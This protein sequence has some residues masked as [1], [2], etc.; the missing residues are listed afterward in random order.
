MTT[1]VGALSN[2]ESMFNCLKSA[3]SAFAA[4]DALYEALTG[5]DGTSQIVD[6][7][8]QLQQVVSQGLQELV[9]AVDDDIWQQQWQP[10]SAGIASIQTQ[11]AN[12]GTAYATL[13]K[14]QSGNYWINNGNLVPLSVWAAGGTYENLSYGSA[15]QTIYAQ[16]EALYDLFQQGAPDQTLLGV[17]G[18]LFGLGSGNVVQNF[19]GQTQLTAY[20]YLMQQIYGM[21]STIY[22]YHETLLAMYCGIN[23]NQGSF[24]S[25][26]S[27]VQSNFASCD[28]QNAQSVWA[29]FNSAMTPVPP[30][31]ADYSVIATSG[32]SWPGGD[33]YNVINRGGGA[34]GGAQFWNQWTRTSQY[35]QYANAVITNLQ[36]CIDS[37]NSSD[38]PNY[39]L[40]GT[41]SEVL[42]GANFVQ[43]PNPITSYNAAQMNG[44]N[45]NQY[46]I[47]VNA[48]SNGYVNV[49]YAI[50]PQTPASENIFTVMTGFSFAVVYGNRLGIQVEFSLLDLTNPAAPLVSF[51][52]EGIVPTNQYFGIG[53]N[54][55]NPQDVNYVDLRPSG[56]TVGFPIDNVSL[57]ETCATN[58]GNRIGLL[59][60]SAWGGFRASFMQPTVTLVPNGFVPAGSSLK[61]P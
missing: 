10:F 57:I 48:E 3:C 20:F 56:T 31:P 38:F 50:P 52:G 53:G 5:T 6:A 41:V 24:T 61:R 42:P 37:A 46:M 2:L 16:A 58:N 43:Q 1:A 51:L 32:D 25:L 26:S 14:D 23:E 36:I 12:F 9:Q 45:A 54:S 47:Y 8:T 27:Y 15:L 4:A 7:I 18:Q 60:R 28:S 49:G 13:S 30:L 17:W 21:L 59:V 34:P 40:A 35:P 19:A 44:A 55:G 22:Y 33:A 11:V 39:Y 29:R